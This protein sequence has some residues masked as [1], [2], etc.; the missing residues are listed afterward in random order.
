MKVDNKRT[1]WKLLDIIHSLHVRMEYEGFGLM[2]RG[3]E[4]IIVALAK[5]HHSG[6]SGVYSLSSTK[7]ISFTRVLLVSIIPTSSRPMKGG[8]DS[9]STYGQGGDSCSS[10]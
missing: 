8:V 5:E 7:S 9:R 6:K 10:R 2:S 1:F 3:W 4:D